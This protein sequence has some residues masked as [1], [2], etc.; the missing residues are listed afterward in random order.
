M[1]NEVTVHEL[2]RKRDLLVEQ[3]ADLVESAIADCPRARDLLN[4]IAAV[5]AVLVGRGP[6]IPERGAA[7]HGGSNSRANADKTIGG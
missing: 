1:N 7:N 5:D 4:E 2:R 3:H 6:Q